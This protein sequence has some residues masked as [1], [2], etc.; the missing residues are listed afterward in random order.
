MLFEEEGDEGGYEEKEA[1]INRA[2][3]IKGQIKLHILGNF[4]KHSV[5]NARGDSHGQRKDM[6][7][8]VEFNLSFFVWIIFLAH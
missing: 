7:N 6:V 8:D 4:I 2:R 5:E 1:K 3:G